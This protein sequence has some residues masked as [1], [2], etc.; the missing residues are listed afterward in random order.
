MFFLLIQFR[1]F[2]QLLLKISQHFIYIIFSCSSI[3]SFFSPSRLNTIH[4]CVSLVLNPASCIS[5]VIPQGYSTF[6]LFSSF[7]IFFISCFPLPI[8]YTTPFF[9]LHVF[10]LLLI[11]FRV[12]RLLSARL[13]KFSPRSS[14]SLYR[15][16][17]F[18]VAV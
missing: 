8:D 5:S 9:S 3:L 7:F 6:Y 1:L 4:L 10:L 12:V 11:K 16:F 13:H 17:A 14:R 15:H 18:I 2:P